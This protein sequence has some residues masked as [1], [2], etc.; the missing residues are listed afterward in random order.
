MNKEKN[1]Y[2]YRKDTRSDQEF[3]CYIRMEKEEEHYLRLFLEIHNKRRKKREITVDHWGNDGNGKI[4]MDLEELKGHCRP[5]YIMNRCYDNSYFNKIKQPIEVQRCKELRPEVC[6]IKKSKV[7]WPYD[8]V[9]KKVCTDKTA[10]LFVL[11]TKHKGLEKYSL[12]L[13]RFL[14]K[15]KENGITYPIAL[16]GKPSYFFNRTDIK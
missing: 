11:G 6:Y 1:V 7:D 10:I 14:E 13:P 4:V 16:G 15:I 5:D 12:L 8:D 9:T 2:N 3:E